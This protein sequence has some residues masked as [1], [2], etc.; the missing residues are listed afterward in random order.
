LALALAAL[1]ACGDVPD[2]RPVIRFLEAPDTGGGWRAIIEAFELANPDVDVELVEGPPSTNSR[3]AMYAA[4]FLSGDTGYDVVYLDVPWVPKFASHGWLRPLDDRLSPDARE[5]F[6]PGDLAGSVYNGRLYRVPMQADAGMLYYRTD[7]VDHAPSTFEEL[8]T[9]AREA[10]RPPER[11]GYVFQGL[12]YEGLVA[13]FLEVLWGHGGNVLGDDG[14]VLLDSPEAVAALEWLSALVGTIAPEGVTA[15]QE[16]EARQVF[17]EGRAVFM[18]N[19]PYAWTALQGE[20]SPVRGRVGLARLPHAPG[21]ASAAA[22]GGWG[23]GIAASTPYPDE[24]WRFIDFATSEAAQKTLHLR[25]GRIPT[26]RALF[27]DQDILAKSP[28]YPQLLEV[29][30]T[31]RPRPVHARYAEISDILQTHVSAALV[32]RQSAAEAVGAAASAIAGIVGP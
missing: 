16:E 12:Q 11:W 32:G 24:A 20:G 21:A 2:R 13:S 27:E 28:H 23:F 5:A 31:A 14:R 30:L 29:L 10:G 22:L 6:L 19:W 8:V 1:A 25:N 26:R 3:E 9:Q 17:Q 4:A 15:Y 18:R 7:L